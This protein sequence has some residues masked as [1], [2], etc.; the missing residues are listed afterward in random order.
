MNNKKNSS[1]NLDLNEQVSNAVSGEPLVSTQK[2]CHA[3]W[4]TSFCGVLEKNVAFFR[5]EIERKDGFDV[6]KKKCFDKDSI[7]YH[8]PFENL[9]DPST[10]EMRGCVP[11]TPVPGEKVE[12][13]TNVYP[14]Q[15]SHVKGLD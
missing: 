13:M 2:G 9:P 12:I 11:G 8:N 7:E 15:S 14:I 6:K 10:H 5:L 4:S 3:I 1:E